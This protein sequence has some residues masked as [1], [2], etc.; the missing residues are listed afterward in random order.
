MASREPKRSKNPSLHGVGPSDS[1]GSTRPTMITR[2]RLV[3]SPSW[4]V[5]QRRSTQLLF[6]SFGSCSGSGRRLAPKGTRG[7]IVLLFACRHL[8]PRN[9]RGAQNGFGRTWPESWLGDNPSWIRDD[10]FGFFP[11][12]GGRG[13]ESFPSGHGEPGDGPLGRLAHAKNCLG[14]NHRRRCHR[15]DWRE[16][17]LRVRYH[18]R[19][20]LECR[21][22][23]WNHRTDVDRKDR[24]NWSIMVNRNSTRRDE[25]AECRSS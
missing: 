24:L 5:R 16:L 25:R 15:F 20:L 14:H 13:W 10:V 7:R 19:P 18:R 21:H 17:S 23:A 12:H 3:P 1:S 4:Q 11:F 2:S 8:P 9:S 6:L 22:S